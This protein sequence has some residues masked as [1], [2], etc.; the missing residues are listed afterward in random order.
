MSTEIDGGKGRLKLH[1]WGGEDPK[2]VAIIVH[3][4]AEHAG[5]YNHVAQALVDN[6]AVAYAVDHYGH[7][8]SEGEKGVVED[9]E[10]FVDDT[11]RLV[12]LATSENPGL[13][14]VMVGHSLGGLISTRYAQ[15]PDHGLTALVLSAP[16]VGANPDLIG[17]LELEE[18]PEVPIDP[19]VLSRDPAVGEAYA[20]DPLVYSGPLQKQTLLAL[21][22]SIGAVAEGPDFGGLPTLWLHGTEDFL[23]PIESARPLV[24]MVGGDG[25]EQKSYE[26]AR[27]EI[28][29]ETN[30]DEVI[31]DAVA[32]L[33]RT[34]DRASDPA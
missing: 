2:F 21:G 1:R 7:G 5:R 31:A 19:S 9:I 16:A 17:L 10:L 25:L 24:E 30:Q 29:N 6:G 15:R 33:A 18:F 14:V 3:G 27:H 8:A 13:P 4:L 23:V 12:E 32:F 28:F 34:L 11:A 22:G 20:A 26:G